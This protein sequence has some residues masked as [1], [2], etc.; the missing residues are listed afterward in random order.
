MEEYSDNLYS[1]D[2]LY[3]AIDGNELDVGYLNK[4]IDSLVTTGEVDLEKLSSY[5]LERAYETGT[6]VVHMV[7][8]KYVSGHV[9]QKEDS[10][11]ATA[12]LISNICKYGDER[13]LYYA[14]SKIAKK[15]EGQLL[16]IFSPL[17][18][19]NQSIIP[20][21]RIIDI[22]IASGFT[23]SA[24]NELN[25]NEFIENCLIIVSDIRP[26]FRLLL[27]KKEGFK[28]HTQTINA[29]C[30]AVKEGKA[31][32]EEFVNFIIRSAD[33]DSTPYRYFT[34]TGES[35]IY[36]NYV[37]GYL[38]NHD[39][40]P[41]DAFLFTDDNIEKTFLEGNKKEIDYL[42]KRYKNVKSL[43]MSE[44]DFYGYCLL[45]IEQD[46]PEKFDNFIQV[47]NFEDLIEKYA[48]KITAKIVE[49]SSFNII[50]YFRTKDV[51]LSFWRRILDN[52]IKKHN[53][54][55]FDYV[56]S[57]IRYDIQGDAIDVF[58]G[59][60]YDTIVFEGEDYTNPS[61]MR[62]LLDFIDILISYDIYPTQ[63][64]DK[65]TV[66][67]VVIHAVNNT[68][69]LNEYINKL[70]LKWLDWFN[71]ELILTRRIQLGITLKDLREYL[72]MLPE[73][74]NIFGEF[75]LFSVA[76]QSGNPHL[77]KILLSKLQVDKHKLNYLLEE[78]IRSSAK[79]V[80]LIKYVLQEIP[81]KDLADLIITYS[82]SIPGNTL[83]S[84]KA[85]MILDNYDFS[86]DEKNRILSSLSEFQLDW[87]KEH[88]YGD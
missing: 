79:D 18:A 42:I 51:K 12:F 80:R 1:R 60:L 56:L 24:T 83:I 57:F 86:E 2:S 7:I 76:I 78:L 15:D 65:N 77:V 44:S 47:I 82:R 34:R 23:P 58:G 14:L 37:L 43:F 85:L 59:S 75:P 36:T 29:M 62:N 53:T 48:A 45:Y 30:T 13:G 50:N 6:T 74:S 71:L 70:Q 88:L 39:H 46:D 28:I 5:F 40:L 4:L 10:A 11:L 27:N 67:T 54:D 66:L 41:D 81:E 20:F 19:N 38:M 63:E 64:E 61:D 3:R 31:S 73:E 26:I 87:F 69:E 21:E 25:W 55:V 16:H 9:S 32:Q 84:K 68:E 52:C 72:D 8:I 33:I 17:L 49:H 35:L 22:F